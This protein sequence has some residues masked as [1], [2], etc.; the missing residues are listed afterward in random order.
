MAYRDK[1]ELTSRSSIGKE[2]ICGNTGDS[3]C[4]I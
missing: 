2:N 3:D 1:E 4:S